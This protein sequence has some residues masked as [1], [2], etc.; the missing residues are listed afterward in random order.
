MC[1]TQHLKSSNI[2]LLHDNNLSTI[3][4][5]HGIQKAQ[6][7][8]HI[9]LNTLERGNFEFW[10]I[11]QQVLT[12]TIIMKKSAFL[13]SFRKYLRSRPY[14]QVLPVFLSISVN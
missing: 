14:L 2:I 5:P 6:Y 4:V 7:D 12:K 9:E 11:R 3:G 8:K 13:S 1:A 10:A